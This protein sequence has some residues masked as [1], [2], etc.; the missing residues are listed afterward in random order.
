M[1]KHHIFGIIR[2]RISIYI[3]SIFNFP[4]C[5]DSR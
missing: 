5:P 3:L 2:L 4:H 1:T